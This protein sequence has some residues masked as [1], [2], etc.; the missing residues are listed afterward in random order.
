MANTLQILDPNPVSSFEVQPTYESNTPNFSWT[1]GDGM[2]EE[3]VL[4]FTAISTNTSFNHTTNDT[5]FEASLEYGEKYEI[6]I[7]AVFK[8]LSSSP[9]ADTTVVGNVYFLVH[10]KDTLVRC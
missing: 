2:A 6:K 5:M 8:E 10:V 1:S 9:V 4:I 3:Y 7:I